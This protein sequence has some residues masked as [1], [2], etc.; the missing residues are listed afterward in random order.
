MDMEKWESFYI[1]GG[2]IKWYSHSGEQLLKRF[3][4][5]LSEDPAILLIGIE[6]KEMETDEYTSIYNS[7]YSW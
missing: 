1:I 5:E 2:N 4:I 3:N 6:L 7:G